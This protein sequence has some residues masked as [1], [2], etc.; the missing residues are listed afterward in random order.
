MGKCDKCKKLVSKKSPGIQCSKCSRWLHATCA[1]I[2][3][4]QLATFATEAV[5]WKCKSCIVPAKHKRVSVILPD[6]E[7]NDNTDTE[8]VL[9]S[10]PSNCS[11]KIL[12][13]IRRQIRVIV[14]EELKR[15]LQ[16]F[17]DKIDDYQEKID[18]FEEKTKTMEGQNKDLSNRCTHLKLKC[19]LLEQKINDMEQVNM[20]NK[21]EICGLQRA[22]NENVQDLTR[23]L[24]EAIQQ[25]PKDIIKVYRKESKAPSTHK[26]NAS[27]LVVTLR[28]GCR[29][30]WLEKSRSTKITGRNIGRE[31]DAKVFMREA[32]TPATAFLLWKAK[33]ELKE[34]NIFKYVWCKRGTILIRRADEEKIHVIRSVSD[35]E[36]WQ[37]SKSG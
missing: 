2:T 26:R 10:P 16:F 1:D 28:D 34:K 7:D 12:Q 36:K 25:N 30:N 21:L 18:K 9:Q 27:T 6:V 29:D 35:I 23:R 4:D 11:E 15:S 20:E 22:E 8:P 37:S 33:S 24:C 31:D 14:E 3:Y 17:S 32:L 13:D 5:D 19:E